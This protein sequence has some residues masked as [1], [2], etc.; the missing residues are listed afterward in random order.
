MC[1]ADFWCFP[2]MTYARLVSLL[3]W[4]TVPQ[5]LHIRVHL[6]FFCRG[7][8]LIVCAFVCMC[9]SGGRTITVTGQDFDLVQSAIMQVDGIGHTVSNQL[10]SFH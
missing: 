3:F 5:Y 10:C 7:L 2:L 8:D 6:T 9:H 4:C 1:V